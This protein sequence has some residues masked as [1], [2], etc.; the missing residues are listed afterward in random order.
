MFGGRQTGQACHD[1]ARLVDQQ[2]IEE[3]ELADAVRDFLNLLL[4]MPSRYSAKRSNFMDRAIFYFWLE[5]IAEPI[6]DKMSATG[7][8]RTCPISTKHLGF[9]RQK[10]PMKNRMLMKRLPVTFAG[11]GASPISQPK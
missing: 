5:L 11:E 2:R 9:R 3:A 6:T 1:R 7:V 4:R 10:E 8:T